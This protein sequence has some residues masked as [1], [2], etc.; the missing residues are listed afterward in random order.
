V[1]FLKWRGNSQ[2]GYENPNKR[3]GIES[4]GS[5][6]LFWLLLRI[7]NTHRKSTALSPALAAIAFMAEMQEPPDRTRVN[8]CSEIVTDIQNIKICTNAH[9]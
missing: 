3:P 5:R 8:A 9:N 1:K 2:R 6:R 4:S 7:P